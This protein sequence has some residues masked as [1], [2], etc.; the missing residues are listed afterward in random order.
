MN[1]IIQ[2][3]IKDK[4]ILLAKGE[5]KNNSEKEKNRQQ[6]IKKLNDRI[7]REYIKKFTDDPVPN[8][9]TNLDMDYIKLKAK[10]EVKPPR[11]TF[12]GY[13]RYMS[14]TCQRQWCKAHG[15]FYDEKAYMTSTNEDAISILIN[16]WRNIGDK[17]K[18]MVIGDAY[19]FDD[20]K[21][22]LYKNNVGK[23]EKN[24]DVIWMD[25]SIP[26]VMES[27]LHKQHPDY[28]NINN[29]TDWNKTT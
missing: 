24:K 16:S 28:P 21:Y 1:A 10:E 9:V 17:T 20:I 6:K 26:I 11:A 7:E 5:I 18:L 22:Y 3:L 4:K 14:F 2:Q 12:L 25:N 27:E 8:V 23:I 13:F 19:K 29:N 15:W